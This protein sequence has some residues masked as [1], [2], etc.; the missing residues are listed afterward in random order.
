MKKVIVI[1]SAFILAVSGNVSAQ[2]S[3]PVPEP[4]RYTL[5]DCMISG[6]VMKEGSNT[7][8]VPNGR[9]T[10]KLVKR[11]DKFSDVV[12]TDA[13]G[14][15]T[16]LAPNNGSTEHLP[17]TPCKYK[18]P[19]AC[20]G[21]GSQNVFLCMCRPTDLSNGSDPYSIGLLL[22][23]VQAAREAARRSTPPPSTN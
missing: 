21:A 23:A 17:K 19:D 13:A 3:N 8:P 10:L 14:K 22:P 15:S 20:F 2:I 6:I 16:R 11:G 5:E 4:T 7:I 9:G 12:Y 1:L 18:L